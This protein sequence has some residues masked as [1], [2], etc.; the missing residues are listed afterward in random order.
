[1]RALNAAAGPGFFGKLPCAGDFLQRRL[2]AAFVDPWDTHMSTLLAGSRQQLGQDW[3]KA[4][5]ASALVAFLLAPGIC[6]ASGWA[7]VL[8]PSVDRVGRHFPMVLACPPLPATGPA[9]P[10]WFTRAAMVLADALA[11][12]AAGVDAFDAQVLALGVPHHPL[13]AYGGLWWPVLP[14][15]DHGPQF[16]STGLPAMD[17]YLGWLCAEGAPAPPSDQ[18]IT[19]RT[20]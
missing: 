16:L 6:G 2:P 17:V 19:E 3:P 18:D 11:D 10:A 20:A 9:E 14:S 13:P 12:P 4:Y 8:A 15:A 1:M 5:Q 7:G